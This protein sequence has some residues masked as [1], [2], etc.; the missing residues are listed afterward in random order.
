MKALTRKEILSELKQLGINNH[1]ELM[2][3]LRDYQ[4]YYSSQNSGLKRFNLSIKSNFL[5][6]ALRVFLPL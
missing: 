1:S 3:Y 2:A 5:T 6:T 4:K